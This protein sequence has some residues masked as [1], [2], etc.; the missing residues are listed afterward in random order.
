MTHVLRHSRTWTLA[1]AVILTAG[2]AAAQ[3]KPFQPEVGQPGKDVVWVPTPEA[4]VEKML[5]LAQVTPRDFVMDLGSGDGRN[6]IA[7][8][9]RG[10][11][12]LGV[13][14]NPD[15]VDLSKRAAATAGVADKAQFV[16]GDMFKADISKANVLALF[17]LPSNLLQLRSKFLE[18]QPG[19]RIVS[20][21]FY[22]DGW[23]PDQTVQLDDCASWCT[24]LLYV[25]PAKATGTWRLPQGELTLTQ[26]F[27]MLSGTL[28]AGG[29]ST[30][31]TGRLRGDQITLTAGSQEYSGVLR[32]NEIDGTV[33]AG[34]GT[35]T[36]KATRT[37]N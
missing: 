1:L 4:M 30:Q 33:R 34:S 20:N 23:T 16:Q 31:V 6:I 22:I 21:T 32:G 29:Q 2:L 24:A 10:A 28:T 15:M 8:A 5:D 35:S 3:Q 13:E 9:K 37:A 18:L 25:V 12:S 11:Q 36:W 14:Y 7:A 26:E 19:S 17:L 27:Q